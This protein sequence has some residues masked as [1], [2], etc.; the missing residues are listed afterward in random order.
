VDF[1]S[2]HPPEYYPRLS[3][4]N[5]IERTGY[6]SLRL[7][8]PIMPLRIVLWSK[9]YNPF[10]A[11]VRS[12]RPRSR[13]SFYSDSLAY[14]VSCPLS[15][16]SISTVYVVYLCTV[17]V[18]YSIYYSVC[19]GVLPC[20]AAFSTNGPIT[21]LQFSVDAGALARVGTA[22]SGSFFNLLGRAQAPQR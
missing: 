15:G 9:Q 11:F 10:Q 12:A 17:Y 6:G 20:S 21:C 4:F 14:F 5:F 1:P 7:I 22:T 2:G 8:W 19:S 13:H 3:L 16:F 18:L